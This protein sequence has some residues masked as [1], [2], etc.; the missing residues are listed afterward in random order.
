MSKIGDEK[1]LK[2]YVFIIFAVFMFVCLSACGKLKFN[3]DYEESTTEPVHTHVYSDATCTLPETCSCG[4]TNGTMLGHSFSAADC[5]S[6]QKCD[7]C[8]LTEGEALGHDF[9]PATCTSPRQCSRCGLTEGNEIGHRWIDATYS[10]PKTCSVCGL[11]EGNK[12]DLKKDIIGQWKITDASKKIRDNDFYPEKSTITFSE[13]GTWDGKKNNT[14][15]IYDNCL[16][17]DS[18]KLVFQYTYVISIEN[19]ILKMEYPG[20]TPIYYERVW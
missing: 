15:V 13:N 6:P 12:K 17:L 2:K 14:Y 10:T 9:I 19:N 16:V 7:R 11:T 5:V 18:D 4:A 8:G 3:S 20:A 1:M